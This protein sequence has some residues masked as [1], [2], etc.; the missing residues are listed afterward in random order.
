MT[1]ESPNP[2][3]DSPLLG[4]HPPPPNPAILSSPSKPQKI[5]LSNGDLYSGHLL[6][7]TPSGY[8]EYLYAPPNPLESY[9]GNWL[10]GLRE[11]L[12]TLKFK[13]GTVFHGYWKGNR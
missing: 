5:R 1:P 11:G 6:S 12:G 4:K 10:D 8:G 2:T 3:T 7:R 9:K 13:N